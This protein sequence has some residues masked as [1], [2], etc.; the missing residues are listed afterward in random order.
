MSD[1]QAFQKALD[2]LYDTVCSLDLDDTYTMYAIQAVLSHVM[3][4]NNKGT[5]R[6]TDGR[7]QII[8][9]V[10]PHDAPRH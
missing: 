6:S 4:Q 2:Q 7:T 5:I 8:S 3:L 9:T 1:Q 10:M